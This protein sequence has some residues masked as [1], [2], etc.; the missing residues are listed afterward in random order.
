[1]LW[2]NWLIKNVSNGGKILEVRGRGTSVDRDRHDGIHDPERLRQEMGCRRG[3]G[4]VG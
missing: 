4:K 3:D 2:A 1:M